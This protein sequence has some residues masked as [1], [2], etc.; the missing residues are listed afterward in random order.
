[1]KIF[2]MD[3]TVLT[4]KC[5]EHRAFNW[6][7]THKKFI[8]PENELYSIPNDYF[9]FSPLEN[10]KFSI[11]DLNYYREKQ[12]DS[13]SA[14]YDM[15]YFTDTYGIYYN[16][17]YRD[18][19]QTEHS[20]K[21]YGGLDYND[22]LFLKN[23]RQKKKLILTEFNLLATPTDQDIRQKTEE[24]LGIKWS[25]WTARYF[26][27]LDTLENP[28]LPRWVVH[29]Y[30]QQHQNKWPF[31]NSGIVYVH[32]DETIAI[33]ENKTSLTHPVPVIYTSKYGQE[34]FDVPYKIN[35]PYWTDITYP[36]DTTHRIVSYY[37]IK[38]NKTGDSILEHHHIPHVYPAVIESK[39]SRFYYFCGDFADNPVNGRFVKFKGIGY[40]ELFLLNDNEINSRMP[41]FWRFYLPMVKNIL[42]NY[43]NTLPK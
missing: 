33:V 29:L 3:K 37:K 24:L 26:E 30:K 19:N 32:E 39:D 11:H 27:S 2:I 15:A 41:F 28:E 34:K 5:N 12:I 36:T 40:F 9:G 42:S 22:F 17:W 7:L 21:V 6:I 35:Y 18:K 14:Y 23:M 4:K 16:D 31:K 8:T 25:G 13:L 10:K 43:Y 1:M 20:E 38:T